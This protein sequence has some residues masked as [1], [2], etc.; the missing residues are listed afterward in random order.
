[1]STI[2]VKGHQVRLSMPT[3]KAIFYYDLEKTK[4]EAQKHVFSCYVN[5]LTD[6]KLIMPAIGGLMHYLGFNTV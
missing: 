2:A 6:F 1:M 5:N 4:S 3:A